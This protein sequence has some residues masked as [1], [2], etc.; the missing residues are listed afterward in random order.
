MGK[1]TGDPEAGRGLMA[2]PAGDNG[3]QARGKGMLATQQGRYHRKHCV[4]N[5]GDFITN[6]THLNNAIPNRFNRTPASFL[7][8]QFDSLEQAL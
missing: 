6:L 8:R 4:D 7:F 2:L 5:L 3:Q 1:Q